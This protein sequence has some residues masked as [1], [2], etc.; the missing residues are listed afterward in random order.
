[1]LRDRDGTEAITRGYL[2]GLITTDEPLE[3]AADSLL[4]RFQTTNPS[5][6]LVRGQRKPITVDDRQGV[7]IFLEGPSSLEG[8]R[9]Y[10]WIVTAR[11]NEGLFYLVMISPQTEYRELYPTFKTTIDSVKLD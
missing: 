7:S 5:L 10:V 11:T 2:L 1:V 6:R 8:Q 9:E 3:N 4:E